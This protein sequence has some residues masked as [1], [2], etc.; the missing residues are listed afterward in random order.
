MQQIT[1]KIMVWIFSLFI[2]HSSL[3]ANEAILSID[4][5]GHTALI[6][7]IIVTKSGDII[8][9]S[10]DK[11]IRVWSSSN[12]SERRKILGDIGTDN[13]NIFAIAL[14][15]NEKYLAVSGLLTGETNEDKSSIRLY[16]YKSG[17]LL[18]LLKSHTNV[19]FDLAFSPDGK[20]LAS[21]SADTT[22]K[23][24]DM[25]VIGNKDLALLK[26][27]SWVETQPQITINFHTNDVY[28]VKFTDK[29][30]IISAGLDNQIALHNIKGNIIGKPYTYSENLNYIATNGKTIATCGFSSEI[31]LFD[32]SSDMKLKKP[33]TIQTETVP[34]GLAYSPNG[35]F[36]L[37]GT[38]STPNNVNIYDSQKG[39]E[40]IATF[41]KH[42][43]LTQAVAFLDDNRAISG[44][45]E[46]NEIYI[47][48]FETDTLVSAK[49]R[50]KTPLQKTKI[51]GA[52]QSVWGVGLDGENIAWG[53]VNDCNGKNCSKFQKSF[54]LKSLSLSSITSD[55][56]FKR[57]NS[58]GLSHSEGGDYGY[59]DAV[60]TI[61]SS[62]TSIT[63]GS[64]TGYGHNCYGWYKDYIISGGSNGQLK[65]YDTKGVEVASL[66]G[67]TGEIWSIALDGDRLV[68]GSSDQTIKVWDL[69]QLNNVQPSLVNSS[70]FIKEWI[71][72]IR[73]NYPNENINSEDGIRS[74]YNA[75]LKNNDKANAKLLEIP[76]TFYPKLSLF[77]SKNNEWVLWTKEGFF[78]A[79]KNGAKYIGYHINKGADK[80]AEFVSVDKLYKAFYRPD[81]VEKA[82]NGEDLSSYAKDI[83]IENI[84]N[85]GLAPK[86]AIKTT[87]RE[88]SK[89][90][91]ELELEVCTKDGDR[92]DNPTL[93]L[94]GMA[95]S[96]LDKNRAIKPKNPNP[97][98]ECETFRPLITLSSG[99]NKIGFKATNANGMIESNTD[100]I[101]I[102]YKGT[103]NAKP[104][105]HI[106][107]IGVD[108]YRDGDLQLKYS[109]A[110]A[111]E[112]TKSLKL[113]SGGLFGET[114][115]YELFDKDVTK[116]KL[117]E[118]FAEIGAK[119]TRED[120]FIFYMA[121]HG[122]TDAKTGAYFYL[123]SDFR[124]KN[125]DSVRTSG[126]GQ[127][128]FTLALSRIQ[129]LKSITLIDTCN[130]GSFAEALAS[131][132][133][134]QKTAIDKLSRATGRA[135]LVASSK[136]QVALEG[137]EGHGVFT[138][139]M[140]EA[141][142]GKGYKGGKITIKNLAS[143]IED[144]LPERTYQKWGYEQVPQSHITGTDFPIGVK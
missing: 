47:W 120:V 59:S 106:L 42:T 82:L 124:Y 53:N 78:N 119:T 2:F 18:T 68:S 15:P 21:G 144:V 117:L 61:E 3:F 85:A 49:G 113:N 25:H 143:Y 60:L 99:E 76:S 19:V 50:L 79:S 122:I 136:D 104:N 90:D 127:D 41:D 88:S 1:K 123:P 84:L 100:E 135:T 34:K 110:D 87:E 30:N 72:W 133:V 75:L 126:V 112:I 54:N 36:L 140:M 16:D 64:T 141:L 131:R 9:A 134:L 92:F 138:Y 97:Y 57:I 73:T 80:E 10:V 38:G 95:V 11:T 91:I 142:N 40:K 93:L 28:G 109:V 43:N 4:T 44:G 71:D 130:S 114:F 26:T 108:K 24:W 20:Y 51:V 29:N 129:A 58:N 12:R 101:T 69:G 98:Q 46:N 27:K 118:K 77:V 89:K 48:N 128:D 125:E 7:D 81:L 74:F 17:K 107:A 31:L 35:R 45:G 105:L 103:S 66:I 56:N 14:S 96:I 83:N 33:T 32:I 94:N 23:L 5:G 115:T 13:G 52:G 111:K 67:H 63:N 70:W 116:E 137:Y 22:V 65:I 139:T 37:A 102:N 62:N 121:G 86:V 6:R 39:Y 132:G 8:S 55:G